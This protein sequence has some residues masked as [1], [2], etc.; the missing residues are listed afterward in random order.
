MA[1]PVL[2]S[3]TVSIRRVMTSSQ[4]ESI[5]VGVMTVLVP[6]GAFERHCTRTWPRIIVTVSRAELL[7][8][9]P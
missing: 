8:R 5:Q 2:P 4:V 6:P 1:C 9:M 7:P 3:H